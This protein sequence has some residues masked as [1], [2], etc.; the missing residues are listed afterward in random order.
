MSQLIP[1]RGRPGRLSPTT[2]ES[3]RKESMRKSQASRIKIGGAFDEW[4]ALKNEKGFMLHEEVAF[5]LINTFRKFEALQQDVVQPT[6]PGLINNS[7]ELSQDINMTESAD[8]IKQEESDFSVG[9]EQ[10]I[11]VSDTPPLETHSVKE[12]VPGPSGIPSPTSPQV[13]RGQLTVTSKPLATYMM[14][15]VLRS[16]TCKIE[17]TDDEYNS[18]DYDDPLTPEQYV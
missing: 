2:R 10:V 15:P 16:N 3:R 9:S 13:Q 12:C 18:E 4:M 14:R 8:G 7:A 11:E 6:G 5:F 1:K 17:E